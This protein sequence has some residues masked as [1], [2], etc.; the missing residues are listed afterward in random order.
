MNLFKYYKF[1][2]E[3][4]YFSAERFAGEGVQFS[5]I[6]AVIYVHNNFILID[7]TERKNIITHHNCEVYL[8]QKC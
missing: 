5:S 8:D 3:V 2:A 6:I 1:I 4:Y 7:I